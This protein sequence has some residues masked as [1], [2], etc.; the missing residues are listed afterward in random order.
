[1]TGKSRD[2]KKASSGKARERER[3]AETR[4][5]SGMPP[6]GPHAEPHL[7]NPDATPGTGSLTKA[8]H[9]DVETDP[10]GG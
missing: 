9:G 10:G 8:D 6:A 2:S 3:E 7:T 5:G 4:A 1:M